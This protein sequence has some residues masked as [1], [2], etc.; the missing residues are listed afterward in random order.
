M[1]AE[2]NYA[3]DPWNDPNAKSPVNGGTPM[4]RP[5]SKD[6]SIL[7]LLIKF[8]TGGDQAPAPAATPSPAPIDP[9]LLAQKL[10]DRNTTIDDRAGGWSR[11]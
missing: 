5:A 4:S 6:P 8:F 1:P 10:K 9:L 3:S 2:D 11:Q 7:D